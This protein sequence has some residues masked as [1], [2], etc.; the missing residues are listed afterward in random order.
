MHAWVIRSATRKDVHH[1][2]DGIRP[3]HHRARTKHDLDVV[4]RLK[5]H[6]QALVQLHRA[7]VLRVHDL[8]IHEHEHTPA[9]VMQ[10]QALRAKVGATAVVTNS[11]RLNPDAEQIEGL[12][13]RTNSVDAH[14]LRGDGEHCGRRRRR[15]LRTP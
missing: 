8:A 9:R 1:G 10:H 3:V 11:A 5:R 15:A 13:H 2:E 6:T 4:N 7:R 14:L 12:R